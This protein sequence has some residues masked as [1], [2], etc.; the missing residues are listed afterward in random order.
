MRVEE[1]PRLLAN[2]VRLVFA[3]TWRVEDLFLFLN[4]TCLFVHHVL[5]TL[6]PAPLTPSLATSRMP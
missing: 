4:T 2:G 6:Q 1:V 5:P 3:G